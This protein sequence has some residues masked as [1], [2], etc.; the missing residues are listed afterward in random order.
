MGNCLVTKLKGISNNPEL[1]RLGE[2]RI[3]IKKVD[4]PTDHTQGFSIAVTKPITLEI[5]GE[6]YFT[7]RT[8]LENKGK[9]L[10]LNSNITNSVWVS[11]NDVTI[12]ILDKYS[13]KSLF[14]YYDGEGSG[15]YSENISINISDLDYSVNMN[16]I[17][18]PN[19]QAYGDI[20]ALKSLSKLSDINLSNTQV[21]GDISALKS[22]TNLRAF[23]LGGKK[24]NLIGDLSSLSNL[25]KLEEC[26]IRYSTL[27]GDLAKMPANLSFISLEDNSNTILTWST[28]PSSSKIIA[29][30]GYPFTNNIDKMLQDQSQCQIG[31]KS[32]SP[33]WYK[34]INVSGNRTSASDA[35]VATLQSK[36]Y[37]VSITPA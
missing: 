30:S 4:N 3:K 2:M 20:S 10:T 16:L 36:G 14:C 6:G 15:V 7:D 18:L 22:L 19:S 23:T 13:L 1:L 34:A 26:F 24:S 37:T 35:A 21:Y 12:A 29:I 17:Y 8:L 32:D 9:T 33:S 31:F 11:N 27:S 5:V 28:R 25:N